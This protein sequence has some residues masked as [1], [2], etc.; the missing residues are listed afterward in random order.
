MPAD[1]EPD[2]WRGR[3]RTSRR[4]NLFRLVVASF[5]VV[6]G[7][8]SILTDQSAY[9]WVS[10]SLFQLVAIWILLNWWTTRERLAFL[11]AEVERHAIRQT[12]G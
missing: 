7:I 4:E 6:V 10:A 12:W 11:A 3:L 2:V 1:I 9:H 8:A 5:F